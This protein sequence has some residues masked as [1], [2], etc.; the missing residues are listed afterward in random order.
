M[1]SLAANVVLKLSYNATTKRVDFPTANTL[2][3]LFQV[4]RKAFPTAPPGIRVTYVDDDGDNIFL[5]DES[6]LQSA[7]GLVQ[8]GPLTKLNLKVCPPI[9][10]EKTADGSTYSALELLADY[11]E[12]PRWTHI[13]ELPRGG[14][15]SYVAKAYDRSLRREVA[16]KTAKI[17]NE[18]H[19]RKAERE[20]R[21]LQVLNVNR[22][23]C[24][25]EFYEHGYLDQGR[26]YLF[27]TMEY[28][29]AGSLMMHIN[30]TTDGTGLSQ[31]ETLRMAKDIL[32]ALDGIHGRDIVHRDIKGANCLLFPPPRSVKM[33]SI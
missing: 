28:A 24:I 33:D 12:P 1:A 15:G 18:E 11:G 29:N 6:D 4:V 10:S 32:S 19:R 5:E 7:I 30:A 16:I 22:N 20:A 2:D 3:D 26:A 9:A 31:R 25:C 23:D 17:R 13:E 14:S 21:A 8:N 27:I